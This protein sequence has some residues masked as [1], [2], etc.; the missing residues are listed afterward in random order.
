MYG[1]GRSSPP[2]PVHLGS[3]MFTAVRGR[4]RGARGAG[5]G[6][7]LPS[8]E[9]GPGEA[10]RGPGGGEGLGRGPARRM[11]RHARRGGLPGS[12]GSRPPKGPGG[13]A[14]L[15][16]GRPR[17]VPSALRSPGPGFPRASGAAIVVEHPPPLSPPPPPPPRARARG[18]RPALLALPPPAR[19]RR[20]SG[21]GPRVGWGAGGLAAARELSARRE[22]HLRAAAAAQRG[23]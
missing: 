1:L 14:W 13:G 11:V 17:T 12:L 8:S 15:R 9:G 18:R 23:R 6:G 16:T 4:P 5:P 3:W 7:R 19:V 21:W 2:G 10:V 20:M 22:G